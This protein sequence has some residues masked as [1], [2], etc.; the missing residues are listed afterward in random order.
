MKKY[1]F[2]IFVVLLAAALAAVTFLSRE[3][4]KVVYKPTPDLVKPTEIPAQTE[5]DEDKTI[6]RTT[7]VY[8]YDD[9]K[10]FHIKPGCSGMDEL[11]GRPCGQALNEGKKPCGVCMKDIVI[12]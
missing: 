6:G 7:L 8:Y 4:E 9:G 12:Q 2:L 10:S 11:Q 1:G 5:A 3:E